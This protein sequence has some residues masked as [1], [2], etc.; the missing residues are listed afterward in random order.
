LS[1]FFLL[2]REHPSHLWSP[3]NSFN[4]R[5]DFCHIYGQHTVGPHH[6]YSQLEIISV[7]NGCGGLYHIYGQLEKVS[8]S[9]R[10]PVIFMVNSK[11]FLWEMGV[12]APVT[13]T[14]NL[15]KFL[16]AQDP[17]SLAPVIISMG[18]DHVT[19]TLNFKLFLWAQRVL[20][21]LSHLRSTCNYFCGRRGLC[22]YFCGRRPCHIYT[23]FQ[24]ISVGVEGSITSM[25]NLQLF[26]WA[27][28]PPSLFLWAQTL[29]HLRSILNDF[30]ARRGPCHIYGQ[31]EVFCERNGPRHYFC[32]CRGPCHIYSQ[33]EV[34]VA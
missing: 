23:Q 18:A 20:S 1:Y 28:W 11:L 15:K 10:A 16:W 7:E 14:V 17:P 30:C 34:S 22:H 26:L 19:S 6:I 31:L 12:K 5:V 2:A 32:G 27:Q 4:G 25:V 24:I 21:H 3:W 29:S 13:S 9:A 33:L 8:V